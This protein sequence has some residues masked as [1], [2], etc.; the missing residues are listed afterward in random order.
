MTPAIP[1][2]RRLTDDSMVAPPE[3]RS[4]SRTGLSQIQ[5]AR[6]RVLQ[7]MPNPQGNRARQ[8]HPIA[9]WKSVLIIVWLT[10]VAVSSLIWGSVWWLPTD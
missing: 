4:V 7:W 9:T 2:P 1:F 6:G 8:F 3:Q 10:S 5:R